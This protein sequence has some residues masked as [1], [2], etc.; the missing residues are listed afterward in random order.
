MRPIEIDRLP[1]RHTAAVYGGGVDL[2]RTPILWRFVCRH[3]LCRHEN[4]G[5]FRYRGACEVFETEWRGE[6]RTSS[7]T[8]FDDDCS[9]TY[10]DVTR[11]LGGHALLIVAVVLPGGT[12]LDFVHV[13]VSGTNPTTENVL[14]YLDERL[15]G[16]DRHVGHM[17]RAIF[18]H[19]S[20]FRQ[21]ALHAQRATSMTFRAPHHRSDPSQP[22]CRVRFDWPDDPPHFPLASFDFG[23][24][25]PQFTRVAGQRVSADVAWDWRENIRMGTNLFLAKLQRQ[26]HPGM[27]WREWAFAGWRS[28]NGSGAAAEAYARRLSESDEGAQIPMTRV[29]APP[30]VALL[31]SP[32][33]LANP[34]PWA[35]A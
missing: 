21:F 18:A 23:V 2:A 14:R 25:I 30:Q 28:Y 7:F 32:T 31:P 9:Y 35:V 29:G 27:S 22:D 1:A 3:V 4:A 12:L 19:E 16:Y 33:P 6:S 10:N 20:N 26:F 17:V 5:G 8:L 11:V 15:A 24:G 13:R 34:S